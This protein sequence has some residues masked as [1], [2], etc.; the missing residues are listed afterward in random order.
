MPSFW[1]HTFGCQMNAHDSERMEEVLV[2][3]GWKAAGALEGADLVVFNTCSVREK[4][5]QKLRSELG[6]LAPLKKQRPELV[7]AVAGC[8][9]QQEGEKLLGRIEHLDLVIGPDNLAELP[10]LALE[11]M[12][13]ALPRARTEFDLVAPQ[14]LAAFPERGKAPVSAYVTTMKGCDERCSFCVVPYTRGPER[15]RP[16]AEIIAEVARWVAA[17]TREVTLLGQTVD[18]Y[19]DPSLPAPVSDDPDESQFPHLLRAIARDVPG[20]ARLRYTSPHPRHATASLAAAH[21]ELDV[22]ARHIHMPVQSGSDRMLKRMIRRYTRAE[23]VTRVE[24]LRAAREGMTLSTDV[25]VGFSS[26]T[27]ADFD[28]TLSLIRE[29]GFTSLFGFKYSVRPL[30][31]ALKLPDDVPEA[32]KSE[33]LARLFE[34]AEELT[35]AHLTTLVGTRQR[36]LVQGASKTSKNGERVE[37]RTER[38]EIVHIEAPVG[39]GMAAAM[40]GEIVEVVIARAN[41]HSL[42]GTLTEAAL[43]SLPVREADPVKSDSTPERRVLP[44]FTEATGH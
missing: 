38:N 44:L 1:V 2:S 5:E 41:K 13:G 7:L 43:A 26:E 34:V 25:I 40:T 21:A 22:L 15:Y 11:Q 8:V 4:A 39:T 24:R 36:V 28:L 9:A 20:L 18:S 37:G 3:H 10:A 16:A 12:G 17:G 42:E 14:F 23:Y 30:T 27:D 31:P 19:R 6:K 35:Q 29:V 32:V 33:R